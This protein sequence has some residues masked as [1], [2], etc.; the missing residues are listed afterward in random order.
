MAKLTEAEKKQ[1]QIDYAAEASTRELA[2]KFSVSQTSISKQISAIDKLNY[3]C[4][5]ISDRARG[6][7]SLHLQ[8]WGLNDLCLFYFCQRGTRDFVLVNHYIED[9]IASS[10]ML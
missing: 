5:T 3:L 7:R 4:Y 1:I 10:A 6:F 2:E 9:H 8:G